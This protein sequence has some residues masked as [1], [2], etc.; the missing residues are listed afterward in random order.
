MATLVLRNVPDDL[1]HRLKQAAADHRRSMTQ[2]AI[3]SLRIALEGQ[4]A[5]PKPG[6]DE[7][8][9]FLERETRSAA[10][11]RPTP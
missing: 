4:A 9:A 10:S 1:Y 2:E 7:T 5:R 6:V 11:A 3:L 8:L